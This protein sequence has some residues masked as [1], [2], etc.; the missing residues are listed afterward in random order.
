MYELVPAVAEGT[1]QRADGLG[2]LMDGQM[3]RWLLVRRGEP[4]WPVVNVLN[5]ALISLRLSLLPWLMS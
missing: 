4:D 2:W 5:S 3:D 1:L